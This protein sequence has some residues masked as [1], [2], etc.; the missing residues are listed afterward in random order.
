MSKS[1]SS[2]CPFANT[3]KTLL[4]GAAAA[5]KLRP[6]VELGEVQHHGVPA[7]SIYRNRIAEMPESLR[8][9]ELGILRATH[10]AALGGR[11]AVLVVVVGTP[12]LPVV[13]DEGSGLSDDADR[14]ELAGNAGRELEAIDHRRSHLV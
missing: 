7:A 8:A 1:R 3:W 9:E 6:V 2:V 11:E 13:I 4:P 5:G 12:A 10:L 14:L